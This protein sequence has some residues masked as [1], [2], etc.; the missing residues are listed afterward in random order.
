MSVRTGMP[1]H[2]DRSPLPE[3]LRFHAAVLQSVG[4]DAQFVEDLEEAATEI[5]LGAC[6]KLTYR[7][8]DV[9]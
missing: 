2:F 5:E 7:G 3:R 4:A 1:V 9:R 6:T 8:R